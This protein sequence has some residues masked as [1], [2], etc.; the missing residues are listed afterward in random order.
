MADKKNIQL[1]EE[2]S[3]RS[4]SSLLEQP[5]TAV[6]SKLIANGVMANINQNIDYDTAALLAEEFGFTA[7]PE[8]KTTSVNK[9]TTSKDAVARPPIVTIMGH[10][11]HGKTSLLD[12]IRSANVAAG[13]SG[14]ITQHISAYQIEFKTE[15]KEKRKITF[16]DTP[17]HEAFS[18]LRAHGATLTDIVILVVAADDG[19]KPQTIEALNHAKSANVK[20]VVAINKIDAPGANVE[21]VKQQLAEHELIAEAYGGQTVIVPVSAKSG[22]GVDQLLEL[23]IL[24][25]DLMELK[26]DPDALPE[27]IVIE[28]NLDKQ[29]GPLATVLVYNGT[30]HPGQVVVV[31][32]TYGRIRTLENDRTEKVPAAGPAMPV[33]LVG[34]KDVPNFGERLEVVPNEK[35]ARS[36]TQSGGVKSKGGRESEN[37]YRIVLK[38]D[39]GGSLAA[40]ED[41][42]SKLKVKDAVIEILSSGIGQVNE[43][44]INLA[45]PAAGTIISFR[46][47]PN[48]RLSDLAEKEGVPLKEYWIIYDAIEFLQT[49]LKRIATPVFVTVETGRLKVLEVFG[50]KGQNWIVGGDVLDGEL[51]AS[52]DIVITRSKAVQ[53]SEEPSGSR[54]EEVGQAKANEIRV[55]K[56]A[57]DKAAKGEQCGVNLDTEATIEKG[58]ILTFT[59]TVEEK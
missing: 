39:V 51:K 15:D 16:V 22:E 29:V 43:N 17:G 30:L 1:P 47:P 40:L 36:M 37:T 9:G 55:G 20:I 50:H 48:K 10:V 49:E 12:Y 26:A 42:I 38:A 34:L 3:V 14:G 46:L 27:G 28:A 54:R 13:E 24:T 8:Q 2:I 6:I 35:V 52:Q 45:K 58:D 21:R 56:L 59:D 23:I 44:D 19:V 33:R 18:A 41:S 11:D 5:P 32:K 25:A 57:V 7:E 53:D 31:G 4:L